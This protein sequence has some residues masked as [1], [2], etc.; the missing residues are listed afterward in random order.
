M[1]QVYRYVFN[2]LKND[3][4][5]A[6]QLYAKKESEIDDNAI[7]QRNANTMTHAIILLHQSNFL[8]QCSL[9]DHRPRKLTLIIPSKNR[10][11]NVL[12][13]AE[14]AIKND[15]ELMISDHSNGLWMANLKNVRRNMMRGSKIELFAEVTYLG[16]LLGN[17]KT[18]S[19]PPPIDGD[20]NQYLYYYLPR[21]GAV[22][23]WNVR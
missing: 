22:V 4:F 12:I 21:D 14:I 23:R 5:K 3:S 6:I 13:P 11:Y 10:P 15:D 7:T 2:K 8:I 1:S 9:L 18:L 19:I 16:S 17:A 20:T